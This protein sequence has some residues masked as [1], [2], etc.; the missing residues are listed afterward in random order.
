MN[1][2]S[3][4]LSPWLAVGTWDVQQSVSPWLAPCCTASLR[5]TCL[6]ELLRSG[7][8]LPAPLCSS[9][10]RDVAEPLLSQGWVFP[11]D[12]VSCTCVIMQGGHWGHPQGRALLRMGGHHQL[13]LLPSATTNQGAHYRKRLTVDKLTSL[14]FSPQFLLMF[15]VF[16]LVVSSCEM[17]SWR[18]QVSW[19]FW[20]L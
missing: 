17:Y 11:C 4:P 7:K 19:E 12:G 14:N 8:C 13:H 10:S 2:F 1:I 18:E 9:F 20:Y 3:I 15:L 6:S 16:L 5:D